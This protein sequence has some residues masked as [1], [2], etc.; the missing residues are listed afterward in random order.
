MSAIFE[1]DGLFNFTCGPFLLFI[2]ELAGGN[3]S[4]LLCITWCWK[5]LTEWFMD[6]CQHLLA[7]SCLCV[8]VHMGNIKRTTGLECMCNI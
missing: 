2:K 8:I 7:L 5:N 6:S 3:W 4:V 1:R